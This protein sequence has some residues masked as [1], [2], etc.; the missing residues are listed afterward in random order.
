MQRKAFTLIELLVVIAIIAILAAILFP[1]FAQAKAAAKKTVCLSN[2][3]QLALGFLLY[4]NDND[5]DYCGNTLITV[6][7]WQGAGFGL[8]N[9]FMDPAADQNWGAEVFPYVK[10][11]PLLTCPVAVP[12]AFP[13][14]WGPGLNFNPLPGAA[15]TSYRFNGAVA[16]KS[17]TQAH[18][19]ANLIVLRDDLYTEKVAVSRP[20]NPSTTGATPS[21]DG[22]DDADLGGVHNINGING[23]GN[24]SYA[25]GHS[26]YAL[27][28]ALTYGNL[29][30]TTDTCTDWFCNTY[31]TNVASGG[32]SY[33]SGVHESWVAG[34]PD[35]IH[36]PTLGGGFDN[37]TTRT[38]N[39]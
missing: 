9:G 22:L 11:M 2:T 28:Q 16:F 23:G 25:D 36:L 14:S 5:D 17:Q 18:D 33:P 32:D 1:V 34:T 24:S 30:L 20:G 27:R 21:C 3:K 35:Q 12:A 4:S 26:K 38:C 7:A 37:W 31:Y 10:S 15:N 39:L 19:P 13:D 29:G 8:P 6:A